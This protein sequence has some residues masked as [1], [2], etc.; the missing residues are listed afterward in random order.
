MKTIRAI[1]TTSPREDIEQPLAVSE[2]QL[3]GNARGHRHRVANRRLRDPLVQKIQ[4]EARQLQRDGFHNLV[5]GCA[6]DAEV[7][8]IV[9]PLNSYDVVST[10]QEVKTY[11]SRR[12]GI[13][14]PTSTPLQFFR[15]IWGLMQMYN[16]LATFR[17]VDPDREPA[18]EPFEAAVHL[19][20]LSESVYHI[21]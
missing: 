4:R 18:T 3:F 17:L 5:I 9:A 8:G 14:I 20:S 11:A 15:E 19:L 6:D 13:V 2:V 21:P 1:T 7:R 10:P 16:P 12:L